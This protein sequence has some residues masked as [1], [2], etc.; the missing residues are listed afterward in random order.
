MVD[1]L[2]DVIFDKKEGT[3]MNVTMINKRILIDGK[4]LPPLPKDY[5]SVSQTVINDKVYVNGYKWCSGTWKR[6][7]VALWH[8]IF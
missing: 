4:E 1:H 7:I 2:I 6:T 8:W 5:K 3:R